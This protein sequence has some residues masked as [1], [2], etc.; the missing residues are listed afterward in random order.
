VRECL[1]LDPELLSELLQRIDEVVA[2]QRSLVEASKHEALCALS[3]GFA[4]E[5]QRLRRQLG[6]KDAT[7]STIARYFEEVVADL[8]EKSH[9]D[10]KTKLLNF[11]W[12]MARIESYLAIEQRVRWC[13]VGVVDITRFKW[14]NDT[15]GH[16]TGDRIIEGVARILAERI[17]STGDLH[18]RFGGDEFC[19]LIS[20]LPGCEQALE[21]AGRFKSAV[22][23]HD[24]SQDDPRLANQPVRVDVGVVCLR[25]GDVR[26][27]RAAARSLAADLVA[28]ADALMYDAK[29]RESAHV[30]VTS[31]SVLDGRLV[32][33]P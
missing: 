18:A 5:V 30:H 14:I 33:T 23:A 27:R 21:I 6:E 7:V 17:R 32:E 9:R 11:E 3:E 4:A 29:G 12:F 1:D 19:F 24:W 22:E 31:V 20:D 8:T 26:A 15:F 10:P 2:H 28:R 16:S 13:G 25:L